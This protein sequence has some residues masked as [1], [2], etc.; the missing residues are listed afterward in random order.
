MTD[1]NN[2]TRFPKK[3]LALLSDDFL[4]TSAGMKD[5]ELKKV[6]FE[7]ESNIWTIEKAKNNDEELT[8]AKEHTKELGAPYKEAKACQNAKIQ[9]ALWLLEGRGVSLDTRDASNE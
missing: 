5:E 6:V 9:Y 2:D 4:E 8:K 1:T 7:A 3:L